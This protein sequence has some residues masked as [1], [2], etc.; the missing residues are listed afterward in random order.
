MNLGKLI[1]TIID[2]RGQE[3]DTEIMTGWVNEIEAQALDEVIGNAKGMEAEFVP[4]VYDTDTERELA[5]PDR[6]QDVY[7]NYMLAKIDSMNQ[8]PERYNNDVA[9]FDAAWKGYAA[10][11]LRNHDPVPYPVFKN[12]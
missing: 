3:F 5:I 4:Y 10:W 9:L 12:Y 8:E 1:E 6:F 7:I 2:L 11:H